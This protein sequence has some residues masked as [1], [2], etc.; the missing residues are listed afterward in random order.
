MAEEMRSSSNVVK[1]EP[2]ALQFAIVLQRNSMQEL[3]A[4]NTSKDRSFSFKVKTTNPKRYCVRP[5]VGIVWA[6]EDARVTVQLPSFSDY[7]ADMAKCKDKFQVLTLELPSD[8]AQSLKA[9]DADSQ[10]KELTE[11]WGDADRAKEATID[12]IRCS[13]TREMGSLSE[14]IPEEDEKMTPYSPDGA[15]ELRAATE[16]PQTP[17]PQTPMALTPAPPAPEPA[18]PKAEFQHAEVQR[19]MT[20]R[21]IIPAV[22]AEEVA[23]VK[24]TAG[25]AKEAAASETIKKL[26]QQ[27]SASEATVVELRQ[28]LEVRRKNEVADVASAK[29]THSGPSWLVVVVFMLLAFGAGLFMAGQQGN[30][31]PPPSRKRPARLR[32]EL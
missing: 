27:L 20:A 4:T 3:R 5:N 21:E 22:A 23:V 13:F 11:L 2:S 31:S 6:G 17:A 14:P 24:P 16:A 30:L 26:E 7:P 28:K 18:K 9:M 15:G 25:R 8:Q 12:K 19:S 32:E 1:W 10:R 29:G